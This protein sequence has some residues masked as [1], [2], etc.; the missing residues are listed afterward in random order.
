[1]KHVKAKTLTNIKPE[2]FNIIYLQD[3][4]HSLENYEGITW[5]N[6]RV[7]DSDTKYIRAEIAEWALKLDEELLWEPNAGGKWRTT[8]L[9]RPIKGG[10]MTGYG[11]SLLKAII[12][13]YE[14]S[15]V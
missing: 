9:S 7:D 8:D 12:N 4:E 11:N 2:E 13:L 10:F 3:E 5:C 14:K 1:M 6:E 15:H